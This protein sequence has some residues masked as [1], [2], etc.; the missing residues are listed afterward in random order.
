MLDVH[1]V[2]RQLLD[3]YNS[4]D[5]EG[6]P[7][8]GPSTLTANTR[9][10]LG[11]RRSKRLGSNGDW[12]AECRELLELI[13]TIDDSE[14]FRE[15]VDTLEHPDYLQV[16]D[17]PMDLRTVKEDLLGGNYEN[18]LEFAKDIRLIF[19][20]SRN[21]N[22]NKRSRIYSM[23]LR[24]STLFEAHIKSIIYDWKSAK[25]RG[26]ITGTPTK[27]PQ[28]TTR[29]KKSANHKRDKKEASTS[30]RRSD[31]G[32]SDAG[33]STSQRAARPTTSHAVPSTSHLRRMQ[34]PSTSHAAD[35]QPGPSRR[36]PP[37]KDI[38]K[39]NDS[40]SSTDSDVLPLGSSKRTLRKSVRQKEDQHDS[41]DVYE[42]NGTR[43]SSK[44]LKKRGKKLTKVSTSSSNAPRASKRT[45]LARKTSTEE[46][47]EENDDETVETS[48]AEGNG[49]TPTSES[50]SSSDNS[51]DDEKPLRRTR[52]T[53]ASSGD[54]GS[55]QNESERL[56]RRRRRY[57][58]DHSYH[59][60]MPNS[61]RRQI[62]ESDSDPTI[63]RPTRGSTR[64]ALQAWSQQND[65]VE[66]ARDTDEPLSRLRSRRRTQPSESESPEETSISKR[67]SSN[68][69]TR[70]TRQQ[71]Q[72]LEEPGSSRQT[73]RAHGNKI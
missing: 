53:A 2:Y 49:S 35:D 19:Q 57:E 63:A 64:R 42:P 51:T 4:S 31:S 12:K 9:R 24:L 61:R 6:E 67:S 65:S 10:S 3:S 68:R 47:S 69:T 45:R 33:P 8:P 37:R 50:S 22:T 58:S 26:K 11:S 72:G 34:G 18:P 25:R 13:W 56:N 41:G 44:K 73:R 48:M 59:M 66:E 70:S 46:Q 28:Q 16:V 23:T 7:E 55:S 60:D 5:S 32:G 40:D 54:Q 52:Q 15:P 71:Q 38:P 27:Q 14:P 21:Y 43:N 39:T 36:R 29:N 20:N 62:A 30:L 17:T 1:T